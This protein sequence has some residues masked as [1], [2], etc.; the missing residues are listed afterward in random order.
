[1]K[2]NTLF[3]QMAGVLIL[4]GFLAACDATVPSSASTSI[5]I[6]ATLAPQALIARQFVMEQQGLKLNQ[7]GL[8]WALFAVRPSGEEI[9]AGRFGWSHES[10]GV[11]VNA[12]GEVTPLPDLSEQAKIRAVQRDK[13]LKASLLAVLEQEYEPLP[14]TRQL[15]WRGRIEVFISHWRLEDVILDLEGNVVDLEALRAAEQAAKQARCIKMEPW[16]C[17]SQL[18]EDPEATEYLMIAP[19]S[20]ADVDK[21]AKWLTDAGYTSNTKQGSISTQLPRYLVP[22]LA[23][24][25]EVQLVGHDA[26]PERIVPLDGRL[27]FTFNLVETNGQFSLIMISPWM[28][29]SDRDMYL[30][31]QLT[32]SAANQFKID[33][34]GI[35]YSGISSGGMSE[36]Y[37]S[38][39][40]ALG[41]LDG[42]YELIFD[43]GRQQDSYTLHVT[44][45]SVTLEPKSTQFTQAE[46]T[47]LRRPLS[48]KWGYLG[49]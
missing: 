21:V 11:L 27:I 7:L 39:N 24:L 20:P 8:I 35:H 12:N 26:P 47:S 29:S 30:V 2:Q 13:R 33:M 22:E 18:S 36:T 6:P 1:M 28:G 34:Q 25:D 31:A 48:A 14:W 5:S 49:R 44:S 15:I 3:S 43:R 40:A 38:W 23:A 10:I 19:Q 9:W 4:L 41:Q 45:D 42:D 16:L 37:L 17:S 32:Q 46:S